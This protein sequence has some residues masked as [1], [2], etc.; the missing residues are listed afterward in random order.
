MNDVL[1]VIEGV[2]NSTIEGKQDFF[3]EV[4]VNTNKSRKLKN[5]VDGKLPKALNYRESKKK[6]NLENINYQ[7]VSLI[8]TQN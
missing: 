7:N 3:P 8:L 6:K 5:K 4:E 1:W 2:L